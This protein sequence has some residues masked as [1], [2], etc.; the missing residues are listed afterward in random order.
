MTKIIARATNDRGQT[1]E[2]C[3]EQAS[4]WPYDV[5]HYNVFVDGKPQ[6]PIRQDYH[7]SLEQFA[8]ACR[9]EDDS[10]D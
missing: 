2:F 8:N 9:V 1:V 4:S 7:V 10:H 3:G 6:E 5:L